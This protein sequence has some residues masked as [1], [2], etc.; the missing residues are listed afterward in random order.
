MTLSIMTLS[1]MTLRMTTLSIMKFNVITL[2]IKGLFV[3]LSRK[4]AHNYNALP[5]LSV[6]IVSVAFYSLLC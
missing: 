6:I 1:I 3:T 5:M 2:S 4:D